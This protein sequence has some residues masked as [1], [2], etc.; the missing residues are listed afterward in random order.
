MRYFGFTL[1]GSGSWSQIMLTDGMRTL[2]LRVELRKRSVV[3]RGSYAESAVVCK[4]ERRN[5]LQWSKSETAKCEKQI[6]QKV[7]ARRSRSEV[8]IT[9]QDAEH[10]VDSGS[11]HR[12]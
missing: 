7:R 3:I 8:Y 5:E 2:V 9:S 12:R 1:S 6:L 10:A 11:D 4:N